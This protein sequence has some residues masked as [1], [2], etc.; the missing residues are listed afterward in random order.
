[1][2]PS[3]SPNKTWEGLIGGVLTAT[4]IGAGRWWI[5]P[6]AW[7]QAALLAFVSCLMGF[8]GGLVMSSIKRDR[9]VQDFGATIAGHGGIIDRLDSLSFSAPVIFLLVR[10][11]FAA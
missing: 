6:F 10:F 9:G 8:F 7:W 5:T 1:V 2:A 4:A 3:V 11:F